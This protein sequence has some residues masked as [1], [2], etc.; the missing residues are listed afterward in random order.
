MEMGRRYLN[1]RYYPISCNPIWCEPFWPDALPARAVDKRPNGQK[2]ILQ[3]NLY[4]MSFGPV[5]IPPSQRDYAAISSALKF[6]EIELTIADK[7]L[8]TR[9]YIAEII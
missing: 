2:L 4:Q 3:A 8:A 9:A 5:R 6:I 7:V 1:G